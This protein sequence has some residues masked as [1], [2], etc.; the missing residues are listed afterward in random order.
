LIQNVKQAAKKVEFVKHPTDLLEPSNREDWHNSPHTPELDGPA[1]IPV[2]FE[3]SQEQSSKHHKSTSE[4]RGHLFNKSPYAN[5]EE[6]LSADS[7]AYDFTRGPLGLNKEVKSPIDAM[8][9]SSSSF[10]RRYRKNS[11]PV[12]LS[13]GEES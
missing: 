7:M 9:E 6:S 12:A 4:K 10:P 1:A 5:D 13:Y 8:V 11:N 3:V 2:K